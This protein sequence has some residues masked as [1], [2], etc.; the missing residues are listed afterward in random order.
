MT[1]KEAY[2]FIISPNLGCPLLISVK[3]LENGGPLNLIVAGRYESSVVPLEKI[4]SSRLF[5]RA[6]YG[7][8]HV[9]ADV[10]LA[11][12]GEPE[13]IREW[14]R[15]HDLKGIE[16]TRC[17]ISSELHYNVLGG[18][19]RYWKVNA[20]P[21]RPAA[22]YSGLL[23]KEGDQYLSC[24]Y[25]L[26]S[27]DQATGQEKIN[28]HAVQFVKCSPTCT[29]IHATDLHIAKRNDEML[30]EVLKDKTPRT[31]EAVEGDF[32]N[33]NDNVRRF[34]KEANGLADAGRLDFVVLTGDLVDF[35]FIG[36]EGEV[37]Y[38]ENNW[39]VFEN[40]LLG[41]GRERDRTPANPGIKVAVFTSTGNHDWRLHPYNP[42]MNNTFGIKRAELKNYKYKGYDSGLYNDERARRSNELAGK[43]LNTFQAGAMTPNEKAM[44]WLTRK[45]DAFRLNRIPRALTK[46]VA[47]GLGITA[48]FLGS[49]LGDR[50][51]LVSSAVIE[52]MNWKDGVLGYAMNPLALALKA[53]Y[54]LWGFIIVPVVGLV[55]RATEGY[56]LKNLSDTLIDNS[57]RAEPMALH[58][59][60][61][62]INPFL[63]YGFSYAGH[64]FIVMDT[65]CD[66]FTG[67]I[68]DKEH[69]KY[70]KK[71][72]V[73]DNLLGG[74]PD[75]RGFDAEQKYYNWSQIVWL[76]KVL[77]ASKETDAPTAKTFVFLHSPP[78][79]EDKRR[80]DPKGMKESESKGARSWIPEKDCNLTFG[81]LNHHLSQF[82]YLCLGFRENELPRPKYGFLKRLISKR[83]LDCA[84]SSGCATSSFVRSARKSI[85]LCEG[86]SAADGERGWRK[87]SI[88]GVDIVFSGHAHKNIEFRIEKDAKHEVRIYHDDYSGGYELNA[89][90]FWWRD[91]ESC[92]VVQTAGCGAPSEEFNNPPYYRTVRMDRS[93]KILGF[94]VTDAGCARRP[95]E[96]KSP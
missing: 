41:K 64:A 24:L 86:C 2:P 44:L 43:A 65:G 9:S 12:T 37:N 21:A 27:V 48:T 58:Y 61:K 34:I 29:F 17:L 56:V 84:G 30:D 95:P 74:S 47:V 57:L 28:Y 4:L 6:S 90:P 94:R 39:K 49:S 14:N 31:R 5:L 33:F 76:E 1:S 59:Y 68:L 15:L 25:D 70:L 42:L 19:V 52:I 10:P 35:S 67:Q 83:L 53:I 54:S 26:V 32:I 45:F 62:N 40:I 11:I 73:N 22:G 55:V 81:T 79:N 66:V 60:L 8:S 18:G 63:D 88:K 77:A 92:V 36:W 38:D 93:G 87:R 46:P 7:E 82:F 96:D 85:G 71:L 16:E 75:S 91:R 51:E 80:F 72:S 23:R 69:S 50:P 3:D 20:A 13:E 89:A 78:I